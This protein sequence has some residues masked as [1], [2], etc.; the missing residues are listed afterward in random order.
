M[1]I[2]L[3]KA[4]A[5]DLKNISAV[6]NNAWQVEHEGLNNPALLK[7]LNQIFL[8]ERLEERL[9][10]IASARAQSDKIFFQVAILNKEV[11]GFIEA[12]R[13]ED[14]VFV[15]RL[16]VEPKY[17]QLGIGSKL[18]ASILN[19]LRDQ[20][21]VEIIVAAYNQSNIDFYQKIGFSQDKKYIHSNKDLPA[22]KMTLAVSPGLRDLFRDS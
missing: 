19:W 16:Y 6:H 9:D 15:E 11:V 1:K 7:R 2:R 12:T 20:E 21:R 17:H 3:R 18:I 4:R 8:P 14:L 22:I 5:S 13:K 10:K